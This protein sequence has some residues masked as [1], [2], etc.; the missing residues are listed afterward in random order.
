MSL[1]FNDVLMA[2]ATAATMTMIMNTSSGTGTR[3]W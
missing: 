3:C 1:P 2:C